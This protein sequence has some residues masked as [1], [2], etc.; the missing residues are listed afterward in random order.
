MNTNCGFSNEKIGKILHTYDIISASTDDEKILD[1]VIKKTDVDIITLDYCEY[2][3]FFFNRKLLKQAVEKQI[4]FEIQYS[5]ALGNS[6][7][8]RKTFLN[9]TSDICSLVDGKNIIMSWGSADTF[10]HRNPHDVFSL[11]KLINIPHHKLSDT[12]TKNCEKWI[13]RGKFRKS[14]KGIADVIKDSEIDNNIE[15]KEKVTNSLLDQD[16]DEEAKNQME[17]D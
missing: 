7:A 17:I 9:K 15:Y 6:K 2:L 5:K 14:F 11:G 4:M 3:K 13:K 12:L 8:Y 16:H 10:L 1:I